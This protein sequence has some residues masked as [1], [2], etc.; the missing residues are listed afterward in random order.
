MNDDFPGSNLEPRAE[1]ATMKEPPKG[2][3]VPAPKAGAEPKVRIII[4]ESDALPPGGV[5][6]AVNGRSFMI[7]PGVE[8]DVPEGVVDVLN[9]AIESVPVK[10]PGT[11]QVVGFKDRLRYPYRVITAQRPA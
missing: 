4:E 2:K 11:D 6:I 9:H 10:A 8:V 7:Q 1:P 5:F 3:R